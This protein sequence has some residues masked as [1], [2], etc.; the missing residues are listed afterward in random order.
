MAVLSDRRDLSE[1]STALRIILRTGDS[2]K[3]GGHTVHLPSALSTFKN[4]F[5]LCTCS[6]HSTSAFA[7]LLL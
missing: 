6:R 7:I 1:L 3:S 2:V 4:S 5:D